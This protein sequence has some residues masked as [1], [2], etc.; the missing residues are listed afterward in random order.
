MMSNNTENLSMVTPLRKLTT[1]YA[2]HITAF[3]AREE[4]FEE[5]ADF[6][7]ALLEHMNKGASIPP[8]FEL[9][10]VTPKL[11]EAVRGVLGEDSL[12]LD[13]PPHRHADDV[14]LHALIQCMVRG[15]L[16]YKDWLAGLVGR[17]LVLHG[18]PDVL[19]VFAGADRD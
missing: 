15:E 18:R 3:L 14:W 4:G 19:E 12:W 16:R 1:P 8:V 17:V 5:H 10:E 9:F 13:F 2:L 11:E 6:L 7:D